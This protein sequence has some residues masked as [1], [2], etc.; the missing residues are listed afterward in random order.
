MFKL[1]NMTTISSIQFNTV[2]YG[3]KVLY[4]LIYNTIQFNSYNT[5]QFNSVQIGSIPL[6]SVPYSSI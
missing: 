6:K 1:V 3:Y 2:P 4:I 5:I